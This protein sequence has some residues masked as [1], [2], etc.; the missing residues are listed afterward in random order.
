MRTRG[1]TRTI[2]DSSDRLEQVVCIPHAV[3]EMQLLY[4][5]RGRL[6]GVVYHPDRRFTTVADTGCSMTVYTIVSLETPGTL[7]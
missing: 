2:I 4:T 7:A 6:E 1:L 3:V 5:N